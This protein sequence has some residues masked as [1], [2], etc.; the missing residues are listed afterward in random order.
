MFW[1][2]VR[3]I[4]LGVTIDLAGSLAMAL[5]VGIIAV[6]ALVVHG[7]P[8]EHIVAKL[9]ESS[10]L[11]A[12]VALGGMLMSMAGGYASAA[13]ADQSKLLHA[14][15]SGFVAVGLNLA[16]LQYPYGANLEL[17]QSLA[18]ASMVPCALLG[19]WLAMP[20]PMAKAIK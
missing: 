7:N 1:R 8:A 20:V 16:L 4:W 12:F 14:L 5:F 13:A 15:V 19:G 10:A 17:L 9:Q 2:S 3:A 6:T 11:V 18:L